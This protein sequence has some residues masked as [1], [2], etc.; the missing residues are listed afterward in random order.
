MIVISVGS[1]IQPESHVRSALGSLRHSF[2]DLQVSRVYESRAVGFE[3]ANFLNLVVCAQT[4]EAPEAVASRLRRIESEHRRDRSGPRFGPRTLDLDLL[5]YD[6]LVREGPGIRLPRAEITEQAF[7]LAP[8][9][10]VLPNARHP[11]LGETYA[12]L[13]AKFDQ[14]SQELWPIPFAWDGEV[15]Q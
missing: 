1:N 10:D 3:G 11:V 9:A 14:R 6:D 5:L 15:A 4:D 8:L 2:G 12:Q 7:V 13:W